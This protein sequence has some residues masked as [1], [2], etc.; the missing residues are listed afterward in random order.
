MSANTYKTVLLVGASGDIGKVILSTLLADSN[1]KISVLSRTDSPATFSSSVNVIKVNYSDRTALVNALTDQDVVISAVGVEAIL[2]N[3]D[4]TLIEAAL[5][6][7]VKWL[8]P[9]EYGFDFDNF[10]TASIPVNI[11]LLENITLLK[12]NQSRL[13]YT[14]ISTGAFLDWGLDNN[15]LGFDITNRKATL[16]D[17][18]KY[19]VSGTLLKNFGKAIIAILHHS[20]LTLNKRIY[21]VDATFTQQEA[22]AL[23]EKYTD[24]KWTVE[25]VTT[26]ETLKKAEE[27]WTKGNLIDAYIAFLLGLSYSGKGVCEFE[28]K[29]N[30]TA[31]GLERIPLEQIIKEAVHRKQTVVQ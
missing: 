11:P 6:A 23:L 29:S 17:E 19:L 10:S 24:T 7:G 28:D 3:F 5:E 25:Y 2:E 21:I 15:F 13:L 4:K 26:E 12:Q 30:N 18:G 1:F 27:D 14:F 8:I 22:L 9:S 31:L 16:Y 20:E